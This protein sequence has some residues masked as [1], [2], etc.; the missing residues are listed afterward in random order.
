MLAALAMVVDQTEFSAQEKL[1]KKRNDI[2][3][4]FQNVGVENQD[5]C[6]GIHP[7]T[8]SIARLITL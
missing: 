7:L 6:H 8:N 2:K 5:V 3:N 4:D 1:A